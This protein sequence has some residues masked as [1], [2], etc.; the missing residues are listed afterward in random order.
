MK[1]TQGMML[2]NSTEAPNMAKEGIMNT[3]GEPKH[4]EIEVDQRRSS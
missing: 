3:I 2:A 4:G 1:A